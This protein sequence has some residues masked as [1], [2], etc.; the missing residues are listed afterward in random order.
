MWVALGLPNRAIADRMCV[1]TDT[2]K[3]TLRGAY[4]RLGL[5]SASRADAPRLTVALAL[6]RMAARR[7]VPDGA[8]GGE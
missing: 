7:G 5:A 8:G 6:W 3:E 1:E 4:R 2:V